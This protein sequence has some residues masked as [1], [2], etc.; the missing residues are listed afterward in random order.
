MRIHVWEM[1]MFT[2]GGYGTY[3]SDSLVG[4][5]RVRSDMP[6]DIYCKCKDVKNMYIW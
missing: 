1:E 4:S 2:S 3:S 5:T 6:I